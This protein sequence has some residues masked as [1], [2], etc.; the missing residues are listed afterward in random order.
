MCALPST[1]GVISPRSRQAPRPAMPSVSPVPCCRA[2]TI[3]IRTRSSLRLRGFASPS[4][5][6]FWSWREAMYRFLAVLEPEDVQAIAAQL[7][8]DMLKAGYTGVAEFHYLHH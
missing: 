4:G 3:C 6:D 2:C 8:L 1:P 5:D 7:Y